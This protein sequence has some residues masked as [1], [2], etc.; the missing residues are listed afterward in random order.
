M[1]DRLS[2]QGKSGKTRSHSAWALAAGREVVGHRHILHFES[3]SQNQPAL[4]YSS[5]SLSNPL[6][7]GKVQPLECRRSSERSPQGSR[8]NEIGDEKVEHE[9]LRRLEFDSCRASSRFPVEP[10]DLF[11][12]EFLSMH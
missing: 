3:E 10:L 8:D 1:G 6:I 11:L 4:L 5:I 7:S 9:H 12:R 2:S